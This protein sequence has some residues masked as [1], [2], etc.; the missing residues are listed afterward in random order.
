[1][2]LAK[3]K[4]DELLAPLS[5]VS[6]II[7]R[8]RNHM[9]LARDFAAGVESEPDWELSAPPMFSLVCFRYAPARLSP[10]DTDA[11]NQRILDRVNASGSAYLSHTRLH[12]RIV[13]RLA[14]GNLRTEQRHVAEAWRLLQ[15]ASLEET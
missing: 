14:I 15:Q 7:E 6:G 11:I 12:G 9:A 3:A 13:L 4:R 10:A 8:L 1:M 5:A 2:N